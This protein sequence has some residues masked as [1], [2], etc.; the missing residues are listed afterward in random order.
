MTTVAVSF[1]CPQQQESIFLVL[2]LDF[3][4]YLFVLT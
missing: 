1:I 4:S 3:S 2:L